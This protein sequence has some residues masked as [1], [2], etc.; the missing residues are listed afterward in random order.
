MKVGFCGSTG[1]FSEIASKNYF[2]KINTS[3]SPG[4]PQ[5]ETVGLNDFGAVFDAV[6]GGSVELGICPVE[7]TVRPFPGP[8]RLHDSL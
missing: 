2:N 4:A 8:L 3:R 5:L 1:A 7:N 6:S